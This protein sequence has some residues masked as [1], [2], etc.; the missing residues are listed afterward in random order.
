MSSDVCDEQQARSI[1]DAVFVLFIGIFNEAW[2]CTAK[3]TG[4]ESY[5]GVGKSDVKLYPAPSPPASPAVA[6]YWYVGCAACAWEY[7][8]ICKK[9]HVKMD[10]TKI[11]GLGLIQI[12][13]PIDLSAAIEVD[14]SS[15]C[16]AALHSTCTFGFSTSTYTYLPAGELEVLLQ[17]IYLKMK[18]DPLLGTCC[19][20][21]TLWYVPSLRCNSQDVRARLDLSGC[22]SMCPG[23]TSAIIT[24]LMVDKLKIDE[25]ATVVCET[26]SILYDQSVIDLITNSL[27]DTIFD[28]L[29]DILK[30]TFNDQFDLLIKSGFPSSSC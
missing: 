14:S 10:V 12:E 5:T 27:K 11:T 19:I 28:S 6:G 7:A 15:K 22:I 18:C 20:E 1:F 2:Y 13:A 4:L 17:D 26:N 9:M 16:K 3:K 30:D 25:D 21:Q 24:S 29:N 8:G 23:S